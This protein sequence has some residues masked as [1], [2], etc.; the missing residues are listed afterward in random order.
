M[1]LVWINEG[2]YW[3]DFETSKCYDQSWSGHDHGVGH[4]T[5]MKTILH[6]GVI[7]RM[8]IQYVIQ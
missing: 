2:Q 6:L 3:A 8:R 7:L 4:V 1:H 5:V